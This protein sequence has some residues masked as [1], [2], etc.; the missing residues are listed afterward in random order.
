MKALISSFSFLL[1]TLFDAHS[2]YVLP[3]FGKVDKADLQM[4]ECSFD[5]NAAAVNLIKSADTKLI[6]QQYNDP[7]V[8]TDYWVRI[9]I[10]NEKAFG[11]ASISIP[12]VDS[13]TVKI[14]DIEAYIYNLDANGNVVRVKL[15]KD[16]VFK[17][18]GKGK[19]VYNTIRFTFPGLANG[20][21]IEYHYTR[22]DKNETSIKPWFFQ[23]ELP[24]I[25]SKC[26]INTPVFTD[27]QYR[28]V[29][30]DSVTKESSEN[31]FGNE[32]FN[33]NI[34]TFI[35]RNIPA[36]KIE[37]MM[38]AL[39]DNIQRI[40]FAILP[41]SFYAMGIRFTLKINRWPLYNSALLR[42]SYFGKQFDVPVPGT[43]QFIDSV[44]ALA[45]TVEKIKSIYQ[46]VKRNIS[47]NNEQMYFSADINE[48]WKDK[49]GSS[50]EINILLYNLLKKAGVN[51]FPI[52][53]STRDNGMPDENFPSMGQFNGVDIL[54]FHGSTYFVLDGTQKNLPFN[55]T[56]L[57]VLNTKAFVVDKDNSQWI[58]INDTRAMMN[59]K[60]YLYTVI[61]SA[62]QLSGRG[63]LVFTG[64][65]K[66]EKIKQ[67]QSDD[68][69]DD[70]KEMVD[71]DKGMLKIDSVE[72]Q[73]QDDD[74]DTLLEKI[75]FHNS[76]SNTDAIYF[77]NPYM[78]SMFKKN[79][80]KDTTR[81]YDIDFGCA[82][83]YSTSMNV[84]VA[85]NF[86]IDEVP[87]SI[88]IRMSD[89]SI[90]FKREIFSS[91]SQIVIRNSFTVNRSRFDKDEYSGVKSFF[92]KVYALINEQIILKKKDE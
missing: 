29:A 8:R 60:L 75:Q 2:Q 73:H 9:K 64:I 72:M 65:A 91:G 74:T 77:L 92:D 4:K 46:Y 45:D 1:F 58:N 50:A 20:S 26:T 57:N 83:T 22:T 39:K 3:E 48:C 59:T 49:T 40:E 36:F 5:K 66:A 31:K 10:F 16:Q 14:N 13:R 82:Q 27:L 21:V 12:Y 32:L 84:G 89:S 28:L 54:A 68:D 33:E 38:P 17:A 42:A 62:G 34:K 44:K 61:D 6:V 55:N 53:I 52:L 67:D 79:P 51:C 71:N 76:L 25:I 19:K 30:L 86:T 81:M 80:F 56:P 23:D 43:E 35:A 11:E 87:K 7:K 88:S 18:K 85:A 24:T 63:N 15:S 78:F 70:S 69:K 90:L 47:W 37:S 41:S